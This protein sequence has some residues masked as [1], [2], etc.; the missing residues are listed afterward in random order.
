MSIEVNPAPDECAR[1]VGAV[2]EAIRHYQRAVDAVDEATAGLLGVNRTDLRALDA[3]AESGPQPA[4]RLAELINLSAAA[5]T[6][7]LD[8]LERRGHIRRVRDTA[9][10][11]RVLVEITEE[12][13]RLAWQAMAPVVEEGARLLDGFS[14]AELAK[15]LRFMQEADELTRRHAERISGLAGS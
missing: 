5:T 15:L 7:A 12:T 11:R 2:G 10:R 6:T 13:A 1:L 8:R 14:P 4:G 9:D 3:L